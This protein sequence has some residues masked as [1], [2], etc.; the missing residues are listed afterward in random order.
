MCFQGTAFDERASKENMAN[1]IPA[2]RATPF[3]KLSPAGKERRK[4]EKRKKGGDQMKLY[5]AASA[6]FSP[7]LP[8]PTAQLLLPSYKKGGTLRGGEGEKERDRSQKE[9]REE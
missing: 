2:V 8:F 5:G 1:P 7:S 4:G 3:D 6:T 9:E